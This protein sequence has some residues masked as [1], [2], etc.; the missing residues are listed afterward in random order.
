MSNSKKD[1]N[2]YITE[3]GT[4]SEINER[5]AHYNI[6]AQNQKPID[7]AKMTGNKGEKEEKTSTQ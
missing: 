3:G 2:T 1:N 5:K 6:Q 4:I 7:I